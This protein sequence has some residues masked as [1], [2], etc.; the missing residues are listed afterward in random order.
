MDAATIHP[1]Q[2]KTQAIASSSAIPEGALSP[3]QNPEE[4][5]TIGV[6]MTQRGNDINN[7][8]KVGMGKGVFLINFTQQ[9]DM[10]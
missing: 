9:T 10:G 7:Q 6:P 1:N 4:Q 5:A 8:Q 3:S 2:M